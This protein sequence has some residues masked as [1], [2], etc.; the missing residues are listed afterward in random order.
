[1]QTRDPLWTCEADLLA[2]GL[3][4]APGSG[5]NSSDSHATPASLW[6]SGLCNTRYYVYYLIYSS[7]SS[8]NIS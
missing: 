4:A 1:M 3:T 8:T 7:I 2:G 6:N 5:E